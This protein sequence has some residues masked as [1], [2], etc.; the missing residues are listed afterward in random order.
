VGVAVTAI[1]AGKEVVIP[2]MLGDRDREL[3]KRTGKVVRLKASLKRKDFNLKRDAVKG[4]DEGAKG[5]ARPSVD[6]PL[7]LPGMGWTTYNFFTPRHNAKLLQRMALA[8][9]KSGLRDAGYTI[10]RIDGGWWG[11]DGNR[12]WYYWTEKGKYAGGAPYRPGDPHVDAR[13]YPDGLKVVADRLH[14][15]GLKLGFYLSPALSTGK[16]DN[17]PGNKAPKVM[18]AVQGAALVRQHARFVADSGLDHLFYDGYDWPRKDLGAYTQMARAL[19]AEARRVKRPIAFSI[20]TGWLGRHLEWADEWRT[21]PDI[22]GTWKAILECLGTVADPK[23]AGKGRWNNPDCLMVGTK[24]SARWRG[25][26]PPETCP[27]TAVPS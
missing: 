14:E 26:T 3:P 2:V 8:F 7:P 24:T 5:K 12:R 21:S 25:A 27:P 9:E 1:L 4:V 19:R 13:N 11:D 23:P 16:A 18:P 10:L 17:Y 6:E 22:N 15:R 20:N